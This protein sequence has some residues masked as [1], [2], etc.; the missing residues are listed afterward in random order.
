M[1]PNG[2]FNGWGCEYTHNGFISIGWFQNSNLH[3]NAYNLDKE[4]HVL[5]QGWFQ[6][7][8]LQG[9]M[10]ADQRCIRFNLN[11]VTSNHW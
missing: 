8:F 1:T 3:G 10:R 4:W 5:K 9:P 2:L 7:G 11:D 6:S